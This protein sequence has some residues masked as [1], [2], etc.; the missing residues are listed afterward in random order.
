L[1]RRAPTHLGGGA[2]SAENASAP[3][4]ARGFALLTPERRA[5]ISRAG[6]IAAHVAGA[7]HCWTPEEAAIAGRK[8][9]TRRAENARRKA[10]QP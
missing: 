9:G 2:M 5:E 1:A 7:A 8:G 10:A 6:G 3:R 4:L